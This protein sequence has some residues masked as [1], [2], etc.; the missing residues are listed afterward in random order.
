MNGDDILL[1]GHFPFVQENADSDGGALIFRE[2]SPP[3]QLV[4]SVCV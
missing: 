1:T 3:D 4:I 2:A